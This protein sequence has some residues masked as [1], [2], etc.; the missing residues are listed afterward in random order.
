[1]SKDQFRGRGNTLSLAIQHRDEVAADINNEAVLKRTIEEL[2]VRMK[3][4]AFKRMRPP[5]PF[6]Q[7]IHHATPEYAKEL[8]C[9]L[10]ITQSHMARLLQIGDYVL[11]R[12]ERH[13]DELGAHGLALLEALGAQYAVDGRRPEIPETAFSGGGAHSRRRPKTQ[14]VSAGEALKDPGFA[15][16]ELGIGFAAGLVAVIVSL[17]LFLAVTS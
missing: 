11:S 17:L 4:K 6:L 9:C 1:M 16:K 14:R 12:Y 7:N 2:E 3:A 8:R 10:G 5:I 13:E 15:V